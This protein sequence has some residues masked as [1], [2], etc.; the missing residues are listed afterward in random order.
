MQGDPGR[1]LLGEQEED[2][3]REGPQQEGSFYPQVQ[4]EMEVQGGPGRQ[5]GPGQR[6]RCL[7]QV[8]QA[9]YP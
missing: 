6:G 3:Q 1:E 7:P 8:E 9:C 2:Q 5:G 4:G